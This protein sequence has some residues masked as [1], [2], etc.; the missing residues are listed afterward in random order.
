MIVKSNHVFRLAAVPLAVSTVGMWA[1]IAP[2]AL[3]FEAPPVLSASATLPTDI[4]V[5]GE[6]YR[7]DEEVPTDGFLATYTLRT[8]FGTMAARGPG[9]VAVR[10]AELR[11]VGDL[12]G[13]RKSDVFVDALKRSATSMGAAVAN[14]ATNTVEVAKAVPASVG[15]FFQR[16]GRQATT[17]VQKIGDKQAESDSKSPVSAETMAAGGVA[18]GTAVRDALGFDQQRRHLAK[19]LGVDP[20]TTN[21][22]L[23]KQ[24]DDMPARAAT[25]CAWRRIT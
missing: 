14:V 13:I 1:G 12:A 22:I 11:A 4:P 18:A 15:R 23:K 25:W 6:N 10:L 20:Y 21:P 3:G 8:D 2:M 5:K 7:I 19:T 24:L 17:A 9:M 16:V